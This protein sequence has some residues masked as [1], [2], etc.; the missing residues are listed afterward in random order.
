MCV[1]NLLIEGCN[2]LKKK[3]LRSK[4][5]TFSKYAKKIVC[6]R[7]N[8]YKY[9]SNVW[10][11]IYIIHMSYSMNYIENGY[12]SNSLSAE[13]HKYFLTIYSLRR[14]GGREFF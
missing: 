3:Q 9:S 8:S 11:F 6:A 1:I 10:K 7:S 12:R 5:L 2:L 14:G 4:C 13:T